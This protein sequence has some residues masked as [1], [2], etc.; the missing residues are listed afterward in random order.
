MM[1]IRL[2]FSTENRQQEDIGRRLLCCKPTSDYVIHIYIL[3]NLVF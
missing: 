1:R 3:I 2:V